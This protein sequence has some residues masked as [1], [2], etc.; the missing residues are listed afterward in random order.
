[1]KILN[2]TAS[3]KYHVLETLETGLVLSGPEVKS[4]RDGRVD[5]GESF[6]RFQ[7]GE[8][9]LKNAYI[10]PY[11]GV[12]QSYDPRRDRKLLLHKNQIASM[13][14]KIS[15]SATTLV[16]LSIY[17]TRNLIKVELALA[18]SKKKYDHR[19][20]IKERD[21]RRKLEQELRGK[22]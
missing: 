14:G 13:I 7:N 5:L 10:Y 21:E 22:E 3:H 17:T 16:P 4:I 15:G 6:A 19:R 20:E 12:D 11:H 2:R 8:L 1:M 9:F 18:Q